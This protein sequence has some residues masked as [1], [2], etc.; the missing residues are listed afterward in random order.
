M[1]VRHVQFK[2]IWSLLEQ[3]VYEGGWEAKNLNPLAG[4]I[5]LKA[6]QLEQNVVTHMILVVR[7]K[8]F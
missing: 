4:R 1:F 5:I 2:T 3:K 6:K 8:L 7:R